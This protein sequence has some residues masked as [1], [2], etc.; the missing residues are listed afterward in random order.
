MKKVSI[1]AGLLLI[2][3][4]VVAQLMPNKKVDENT[5]FV[6]GNVISTGNGGH[7]CAYGD[8]DDFACSTDTALD[9]GG[10]SQP[11]NGLTNTETNA[12]VTATVDTQFT[13]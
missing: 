6:N 7:T 2:V 5:N 10:D 13:V 4:A 1:S 12:N 11:G 8:P 9:V 3:S